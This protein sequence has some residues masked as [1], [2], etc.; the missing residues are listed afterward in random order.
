MPST[1][2]PI[3][4]LQETSAAGRSRWLNFRK[5]ERI[6]QTRR[7]ADI[8]PALEEMD[9]AVRQGYW[10]AGFLAYEA[11][12]AFDAAFRTARPG[13]LPLLWFGIYR[14]ANVHAAP[15]W[16]GLEYFSHPDAGLFAPP[17]SASRGPSAVISR[18]P[19]PWRASVS[20]PHFHRAI[21]AIRGAIARGETYQV[22][23]SFRLRAA[24]PGLIT[25]LAQMAPGWTSAHS[26]FVRRHRNCSSAATATA[27]PA[28]P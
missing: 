18:A 9:T 3:V 2:H 25:P 6:L 13:P 27:S 16:P 11:A 12:P 21:A 7:L 5:P 8:L 19:P 24:D 15:E 17:P 20:Q 10:A 1:I 26:C 4:W 23:Y 28:G 14:A 22:N